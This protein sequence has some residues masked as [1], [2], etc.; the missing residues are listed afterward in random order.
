MNCP[1]CGKEMVVHGEKVVCAGCRISSPVAAAAPTPE[2]TPETS[3]EIDPDDIE[4]ES[5]IADGFSEEDN[6]EPDEEAKE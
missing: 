3:K 5:A 1:R 6:K 2:T 4:E